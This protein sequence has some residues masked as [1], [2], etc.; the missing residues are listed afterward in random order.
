MKSRGINKNVYFKINL[1]YL[2]NEQNINVN[3]NNL[4]E[5]H[6]SQNYIMTLKIAYL[7]I[8]L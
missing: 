7:K 3:K 8:K 5:S 4:F 1:L 2:V 6:I